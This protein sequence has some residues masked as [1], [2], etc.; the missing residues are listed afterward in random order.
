M[1]WESEAKSL[2]ASRISAQVEANTIRTRY[3]DHAKDKPAR[4][5][6]EWHEHWSYGL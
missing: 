6:K 3:V 5:A 4:A 1:R 2:T